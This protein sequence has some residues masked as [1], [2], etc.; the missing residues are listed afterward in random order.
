[1]RTR[2]PTP[3]PWLP[4]AA[5]VTIALIWG[6]N[7]VVMKVAIEDC[8]PLIFAALRVA[9]G[10]V[11]LLPLLLLLKRPLRRPPLRYV[12]PFGLL[13]STG[14]VGFTLWALEYGGAGKTAILVYM[15]PIWLML[16]AWP[17]LG[18]RLHGLHWPALLLALLGLLCILSPW[19]FH[20][21]WQGPAFALL[22]GLL[23]AGA[24]IWQKRH[25]PP[26]QD[27]LN[28]TFWQTALGAVGLI[29][30]S[31]WIDPLRIQWSP[32]F[33]AALVYNVIPGTAIAYLLWAYA[34]K[35]LPSG[36]AGMAMLLA[37]LIGVLAAWWQLDEVPGGW[38]SLGMIAIFIAL[39]LVSWQHL[40]PTPSPEVL[41]TPQE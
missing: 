23:W 25:M 17:L 15:M 36:V 39:S 3:A 27:L 9:L 22:S 12:L 28:A 2:S 19:D 7:W 6:Y 29:V 41:P 35:H 21:A 5:I 31:L 26:G 40:R 16:L 1:M 10:A 14:F 30:V 34:L 24:A 20:G 37:P 4:L 8:P 13:Q 33:T 11:V 18:E 38:E 32:L